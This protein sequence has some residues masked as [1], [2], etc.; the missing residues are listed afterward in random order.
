LPVIEQTAAISRS[1][2]EK[3]K[4]PKWLAVIGVSL[5]LILA[6]AG[7][8]YQYRKVTA[9][10]SAV[11]SNA[12][13]TLSAQ[14]LYLQ[15]RFYGMRE[16]KADNDK[17]IP[18]LEEAATLD[19][20]NA[21]VH[22][23]LAEVYGKRFFYFEP[24]NS[25]WEEKSSVELQ[26]AFALTPDL[27]EAHEAQG[28]LLWMPANHFPHEQAIAAYRRAVELDPNLDEAHQQLG[29]IYNHI[30]LFDLGKTE[31][32]TALKINPSNTGA[33]FR[34]A[35]PLTSERKCE[36]ALRIIK[37][38]PSDFNPALVV[39]AKT[40]M[41]IC[42]GHLEEAAEGIAKAL[43]ENPDDR[44]GQLTSLKAILSALAGNTAE[45][46]DEIQQ[47]I[48]KG[49]GFGHFHHTAHNIADAYAILKRPADAVRY[50]Q[51]AADDG[52]PNY[53][54]FKDD[55]NLDRI[56][57]SPEFV[58]FMAELKPQFEKYQREFR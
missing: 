7:A 45:A 25:Q 38:V 5:V 42:L 37:T 28:F 4:S 26:K 11:N 33:R 1:S 21:R 50:L 12:Q 17:A 48:E 46:E 57:P 54:L 29:L 39:P 24:A 18:L 20:D 23:T 6:G 22:A 58:K 15:G 52:L 32:Q 36:Q 19:P 34:L 8:L 53:P 47:A 31:F 40:R 51:M 27:A 2:P 30:G 56:R 35:G 49:K 3:T 13:P 9:S 41:L 16:N 44:G 55:K 43:E 10:S 14:E